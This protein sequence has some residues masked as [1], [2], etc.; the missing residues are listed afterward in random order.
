LA[1][2]PS[3]SSSRL[4]EWSFLLDD[5]HNN[6]HNNSTSASAPTATTTIATTTTTT[7]ATSPIKKDYDHN[8]PGKFDKDGP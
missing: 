5:N 7:A 3:L 6:N 8:L 2:S 4:L 1:S